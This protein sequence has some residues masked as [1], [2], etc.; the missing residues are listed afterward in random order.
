M[1]RYVRKWLDLSISATV[2]GIGL[3]R[4]NLGLNIL[5]SSVKFRQCHTVLH[6]VFKSS[7]NAAI[8]SLRRSTSF[9]MNMQYDAYQ[10]TK[11]VLKAV[12][13][14]YTENIEYRIKKIQNHTESCSVLKGYLN[15]PTFHPKFTQH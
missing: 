12:R 11:Q 6:N 9:G 14:N 5:L 8:K 7:S 4:N 2:S 1:A 15:D 13:Q 10:S 3:S